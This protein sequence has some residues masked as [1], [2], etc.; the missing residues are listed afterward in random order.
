M[1]KP[2]ILFDLDGTLLDTAPDLAAALNSV[3]IAY[4]RP[5]LPYEVIRPAASHGSKGLL[6]LG[7]KLEET[8]P[9]FEELKQQ[10]LASYSENIARHTQLFPEMAEVLSYFAAHHII[11]GIVTNKPAW[12]TEPLLRQ[13]ALPA[14]PHCVVS[15]DTVARAKPYPDSLLYACNLLACTPHHCIYIG[16][17]ERDIQAGNAAGMTTLIAGYGYL[18]AD[19]Q[20]QRWSASGIIDSPKAIINW[21]HRNNY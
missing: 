10:L 1:Y 16:D 19:D 18:A 20:P 3:L 7:F 11:W 2:I 9:E 12:L 17:A 6:Q 4:R 15:G 14:Q 13:V 5:P 21:L 8:H